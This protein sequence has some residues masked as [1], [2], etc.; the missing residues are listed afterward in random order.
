MSGIQN[1]SILINWKIITWN[2]EIVY[3][4]DPFEAI[5]QK[6]CKIVYKTDRFEAN[7]QKLREIKVVITK[8]PIIS[9]KLH[10]IDAICV[11]YKTDRFESIAN[12]ASY[13]GIHGKNL[14]K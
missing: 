12:F 11:Q 6:W 8:L 1:R 10:E 13:Y 4:T 7:G 2:R 14:Q 9:C 5:V 3:K